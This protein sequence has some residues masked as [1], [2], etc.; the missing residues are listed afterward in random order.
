MNTP[1]TVVST[2]SGCG[3]SSL[4]YKQA[5][6]QVLAAVEHDAHACATYRANFPNTALIDRDIHTV[7]GKEILKLVGLAKGE[8]DVLDG[9]P[10]CQGFSVAGLRRMKDERNNLFTEYVRLARELKPRVLVIENVP[11]LVTG[12][13][14]LI[15]VDM[16]RE[17]KAAGYDVSTRVLNAMYFGV[18]QSRWRVIFIGVRK[19]LKIKP[20][21]PVGTDRVIPF[22]EAVSG[23]PAKKPSPTITKTI[24][25]GQSGIYHHKYPR[26]LSIPEVKRVSSF[27][28]NFKLEGKFAEQWARI[29]NAVPPLFMQKIAEH[30]EDTILQD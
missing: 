19:D 14:K 3:G 17:L 9:S 12:K 7:K 18:P 13:M 21:H 26:L 2:F 28:D 22:A 16:L 4:G 25:F 11:G 6:F 15:F 30:V 8:L 29:G 20:T 5:G 1:L 23:L 24:F 27:P 10:P